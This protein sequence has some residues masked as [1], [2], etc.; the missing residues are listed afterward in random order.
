MSPGS[1]KY[2]YFILKKNKILK[3]EKK[4]PQKH[5]Q[6]IIFQ[7]NFFKQQNQKCCK[8]EFSK[9]CYERSFGTLMSKDIHYAEL[10]YGIIHKG[11]KTREKEG[12][13]RR[14]RKKKWY[15]YIMLFFSSHAVLNKL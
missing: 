9:C 10:F 8:R 2:G 5:I 12:I 3:D 13:A 4:N 6:N 11:R 1:E 7:K 15:N 14:P